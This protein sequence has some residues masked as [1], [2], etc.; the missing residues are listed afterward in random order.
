[1][2]TRI[3]MVDGRLTDDAGKNF[4]VRLQLTVESLPDSKDECV[5]EWRLVGRVPEGL[6]DLEYFYA[7]RYCQRVRGQFG[8]LLAKSEPDK[9]PPGT[10]R[11]P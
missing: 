6:Y 11:R 3:V 1:M 8:V 10:G 7:K 5:S 2:T 9:S 4:S